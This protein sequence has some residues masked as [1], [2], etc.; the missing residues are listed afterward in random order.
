MNTPSKDFEDFSWR[1]IGLLHLFGI[2]VAPYLFGL[3]IFFREGYSK[4]AKLFTGVY[5]ALFLVVIVGGRNASK[6]TEPAA[7]TKPAVEQSEAG[8]PNQPAAAKE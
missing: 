8:R 1:K 2:A 3:I 7:G 4:K 5:L 6:A